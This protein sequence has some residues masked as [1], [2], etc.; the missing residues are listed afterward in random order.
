MTT[1]EALDTF[2]ESIIGQLREDQSAKGITASGRSAD[3]LAYGTNE[4]GGQLT[5]SNYFYWQI[6]GRKPGTY[7]PPNAMI[8]YIKEKRITPNDPKTTIKQL[9]YL[10]NRKLFLKGTDIFIGKRSGLSFDQIVDKNM[11]ILLGNIAQTKVKEVTTFLKAEL[12]K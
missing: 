12:V 2:F 4:T 5:G 10:F 1:R 9:A 3:S 8:Q 6:V 11:S 7:A